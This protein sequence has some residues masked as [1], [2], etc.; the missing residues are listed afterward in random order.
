[1][2]WLKWSDLTEEE[3]QRAKDSYVSILEWAEETEI[4]AENVICCK[5]E[6]MPDG[7]IYVDL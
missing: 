7:Y 1:M 5:F 2:K 3:Q 6:R 4:N